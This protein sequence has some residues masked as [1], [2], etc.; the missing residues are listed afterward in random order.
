M[1]IVYQKYTVK[2]SISEYT[3]RHSI[4]GYT[5]RHSISETYYET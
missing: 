5:M 3:I 4:S 2:H 1:R